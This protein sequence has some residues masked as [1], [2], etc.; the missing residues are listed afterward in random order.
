ME[1]DTRRGY[2]ERERRLVQEGEVSMRKRLE[3]GGWR[4]EIRKEVK[5][6]VFGRR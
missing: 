3:I 4:L 5:N 1:E 2:K 6:W